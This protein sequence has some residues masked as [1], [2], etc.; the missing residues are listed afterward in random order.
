MWN[1]QIEINLDYDASGNVEEPK[2]I[3]ETSSANL[4]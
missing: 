2:F 1:N 3:R 4:G